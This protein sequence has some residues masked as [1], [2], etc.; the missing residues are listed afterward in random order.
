MASGS[1][2]QSD[3]VLQK[4]EYLKLSFLQGS[5]LNDLECDVLAFD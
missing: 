5:C 4:K 3:I 2:F 1:L